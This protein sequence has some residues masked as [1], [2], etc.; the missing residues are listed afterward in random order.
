M[1][2]HCS[3]KGDFL[4]PIQPMI[5]VIVALG[6]ICGSGSVAWA[7]I[8]TFVDSAGRTQL[9]DTESPGAHAMPAAPTRQVKAQGITFNAAYNDIVYET[10]Y[11]FDAREADPTYGTVGAARR[12]YDC[13]LTDEAKAAHES[14][15]GYIAVFEQGTLPTTGIIGLAIVAVVCVLAGAFI[16]MRRG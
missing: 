16:I 10:H 4:C 2:Y 1:I 8:I 14:P 5:L 7:E 13:V 11:G 9:V 3:S 6:L 12:A 15:R